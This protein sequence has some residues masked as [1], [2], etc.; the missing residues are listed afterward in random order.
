MKLGPYNV[1]RH[2]DWDFAPR[3]PVTIGGAIL[4]GL[5][6]TGAAIA[7]GSFLGLSG[8]YIVGYLATTLVT[9]W[10]LSALAPKP[11]FGAMGSQGILVN[12]KSPVSPHDFVYGQ[13]RKGGVITY[14]ET[15]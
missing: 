9:S 14:Y 7:A 6:S 15:T 3:D 12:Q 10:A 4:G 2:A 13:A 1:M 5:G 8:A 11:D